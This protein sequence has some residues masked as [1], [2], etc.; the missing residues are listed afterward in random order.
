M[1]AASY[2]ITQKEKKYR[3]NLFMA[4]LYFSVRAGP[5]GGWYTAEV[6]TP[7][8]AVV[9]VLPA[10]EHGHTNRESDN[11]EGSGDGKQDPLVDEV[12]LGAARAAGGEAVALHPAEMRPH[13]QHESEQ[14]TRQ[15]PADVREVI[16]VWED[17]E[18]QVHRDH[19]QEGD[20][21]RDLVG[22]NG[23]VGEKLREHGSEESKEST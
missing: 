21:G 22:V 16:H 9:G 8:A 20:H 17:A 1:F 12:L 19:E 6:V 4:S 5:S 14:E 10:E 7:V 23:P 15:E 2:R 13:Q 18:R 11:D 3:E